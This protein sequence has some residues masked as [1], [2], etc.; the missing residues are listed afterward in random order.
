VQLQNAIALKTL[1]LIAAAL[2]SI[3][4]ITSAIG[5]TYQVATTGKDSNPG[6]AAQPFRTIQKGVDIAQPGDTV[7]VASGTYDERGIAFRRSGTATQPITL[8]GDAGTGGNT[9]PVLY[10]GW[11]VP[12]WISQGGGVF[13]GR[14]NIT[15]DDD[16]NPDLLRNE[17]RVIIDGI[18]LVQVGAPEKL[19][20]GTF[21]FVPQIDPNNRANNGGEFYVWAPGG[22]N[23]A[24]RSTIINAPVYY[25]TYP[26]V[27]L[28]ESVSHVVIENLALYAGASGVSAISPE[29]QA[30]NRGLTLRNVDIAYNW[31]YALELI[32][33]DD[34]VMQNTTV[35]DNAQNNW[36]RRLGIK[37]LFDPDG[38]WPHAVI[39]FDANN[40]KVVD[41][42]IHDNHGE[43]VG[44]YFGSA[45]WEIRRNTVYDNWSVN[46]YI[47]TNLRDAN[48]T[49]DRN[50]VYQ[51]DKYPALSSAY[52][53]ASD[54]VAYD[55]R[56]QNIADGIRVSSEVTGPNG[57]DPVVG[58]I[59]ITNNIVQ[60]TAGGIRSFRYGPPF[61]AYSLVDSLIANNTVARTRA[62]FSDVPE[63]GIWVAQGSNVRTINN[64]VLDAP[65]S[66]EGGVASMTD[67][68][69]FN[70]RYTVGVDNA[71]NT[72]A[73]PQFVAG[74]VS[75]SFNPAQF[76]LKSTSPVITR[77]TCNGA[78]AEDFFGRPR[79]ADGKCDAGAIEFTTANAAGGLAATYFNNRDLA[80]TPALTRTDA[81]IDFDWGN[82]SPDALVSIDNFS[83]RWTATLVAPTTGSYTFS[84]VSDD[85]VRL[86]LDD[87][88]II[89]NW[90]DHSVS[91]DTSAPVALT[92][93][94]PYRLRMEY[95]ENGGLAVARLQWTPP[96][97]TLQII[98]ATALSPTTTSKVCAL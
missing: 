14:P 62:V 67:G 30:R 19:R 61:P 50:H 36:H 94:T 93:G 12:Q 64:V 73:D 34:V 75:G 77:G 16:R 91:T 74:F 49:V 68:V 79:A 80:G 86:F 8:R 17:M 56:Q 3:T 21:A 6:T 81:A 97:G 88:P 96:G 27:A 41:S 76:A 15:R 66:F 58:N 65:L 35:R 60:N 98:P 51:T 82:G 47:D 54:E 1:L 20:E 28:R 71:R 90:S 69:Y 42:R 83:A 31:T 7:I 37:P 84:T 2:L 22:A 11:R 33:F 38:T 29:G 63:T 57:A 18:P 52:V 46:V 25:S 55:N 4:P 95:Y 78:P 23:P 87:V 24:T 89:N 59:T 44:P 9:R 13:R 70:A 32:R 40:V 53:R 92:A 43:G 26:A 48:T 5:A 39:G 85:G 10:M 72:I 45:N